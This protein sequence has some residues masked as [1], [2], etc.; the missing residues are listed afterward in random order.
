MSGSLQIP[1]IQNCRGTPDRSYT[2]TGGRP[3]VQAEVSRS[4]RIV[5]HQGS[6]CSNFL[7]G[8]STAASKVRS[9]REIWAYPTISFIADLG[10]SLSL[11]VGVSLLSLWDCFNYL[12]NR[13]K[14]LTGYT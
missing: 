3:G 4:V 5:S 13:Y 7:F 8:F 2:A 1:G 12:I 14:G 10:G 11:F 9:E 6:L